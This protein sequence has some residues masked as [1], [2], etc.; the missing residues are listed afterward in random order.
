MVWECP[1][2]GGDEARAGGAAFD[3]GSPS[4][5]DW[6]ITTRPYTSRPTDSVESMTHFH[7]ARMMNAGPETPK[8]PNTALAVPKLGNN[9]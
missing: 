1:R 7:R 3:V 9:S 5:S 6:C 8:L 2:V 4:D